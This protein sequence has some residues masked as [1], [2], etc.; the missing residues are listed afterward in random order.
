MVI[1]LIIMFLLKSV[2]HFLNA[3]C[4]IENI[5]SEQHIS[6][7]GDKPD[8]ITFKIAVEGANNFSCEAE[9]NQSNDTKDSEELFALESGAIKSSNTCGNCISKANVNDIICK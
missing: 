3:K 1:T 9:A 6:I 5:T 8:I 7:I 2:N 4:N